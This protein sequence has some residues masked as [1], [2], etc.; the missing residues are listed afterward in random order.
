MEA[1][2]GQAGQ[3]VTVGL[4]VAGQEEPV[5]PIH[6]LAHQSRTQAAVAGG[7]VLLALLVL[8]DQVVEEPVALMEA[9]QRLVLQI[10]AA[11]LVV[12]A[13]QAQ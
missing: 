8:V 2:E 13:L 6:C 9:Q 5:L 11:V 10:Q 4:E 12:R 7:S 3:A 1:A